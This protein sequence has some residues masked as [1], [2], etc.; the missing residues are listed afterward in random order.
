MGRLILGTKT[1]VI[2]ELSL[3]ETESLVAYEQAQ[4]DPTETQISHI[5]ITVIDDG[6]VDIE[7]TKGGAVKRL[8]RITG[9]LS[10]IENFNPPKR[11]EC[12]DR[13]A[14]TGGTV[15]DKD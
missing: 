13:V 1:T 10:N 6:N 15:F 9:Y 5:K 3:A 8:R 11:A 7:V 4:N 14:H 12:L 2:G